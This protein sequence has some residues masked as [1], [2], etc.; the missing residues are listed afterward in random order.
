MPLVNQQGHALGTIC[1]VDNQAGTLTP[2][3]EV[4]LRT[5]SKQIVKLPELRQKNHEVAKKQKEL[6]S[7]LKLFSQISTVARVG[8]WEMDIHNNKLKWT[9]IA[10]EILELSSD[11]ES[12]IQKTLK[13]FKPGKFAK[14]AITSYS[15]D[16]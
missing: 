10:K 8:C 1:V 3:Q 13:Y 4:A 2:E 9:A 12:D 5:I 15:S 14:Q 6:E 16:N 7:T 11:F